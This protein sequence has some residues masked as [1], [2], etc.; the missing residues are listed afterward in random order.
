[1]N[2]WY[3]SS[4]RIVTLFNLQNHP[5][6]TVKTDFRCFL[7]WSS[8]KV[9]LHM[10]LFILTVGKF[11]VHCSKRREISLSCVQLFAT[12]WT[13]AYQVPLSMGFSRQEFW[14]GLPFPSPTLFY[15]LLL[16]WFLVSCPDLIPGS[17]RSLGEENGS[18][19]QYSYLEN[20]VDRETGW[21]HSMGSQR[22]GQD[23]VT[24]SFVVVLRCA[25]NLLPSQFRSEVFWL[26]SMSYATNFKT[27]TI[28]LHRHVSMLFDTLSC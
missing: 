12:L 21:L 20:S 27:Q 10:H 2:T 8:L 19:L 18:P 5:P 22:V 7:I 17:R 11:V 23:W 13:V 14:S 15:G 4:F 6:C 9:Y 26:S 3:F 28:S 25:S 1:M 16:I 24:L